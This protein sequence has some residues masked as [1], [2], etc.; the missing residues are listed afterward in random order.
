MRGFFLVPQTDRLG[1]ITGFRIETLSHCDA[2]K[3]SPK[4]VLGLQIKRA[5]F[6]IYV[7]TNFKLLI[8]CKVVDPALLTRPGL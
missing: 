2:P 1:P 8:S 6:L 4:D 3:N 7:K 5:L